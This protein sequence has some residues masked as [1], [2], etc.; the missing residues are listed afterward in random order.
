MDAA[1][2]E[3]NLR[4]LK[5]ES[6]IRRVLEPLCERYGGLRSLHVATGRSGEMVCFLELAVPE[7]QTRLF[8]VLRGISYG[9]SF[10]FRIPV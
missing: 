6:D 3:T 8:S 9:N 5:S 4:G 10:V 2:F 1:A 7:N